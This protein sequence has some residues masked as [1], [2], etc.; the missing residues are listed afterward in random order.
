MDR[1]SSRNQN[2]ELLRVG[3]KLYIIFAVKKNAKNPTTGL[4]L[5]NSIGPEWNEL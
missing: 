3:K 2:C 1:S 5:V 4:E